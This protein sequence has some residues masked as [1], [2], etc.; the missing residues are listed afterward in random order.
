MSQKPPVKINRFLLIYAKIHHDSYNC[1]CDLI[2]IY[3][4]NNVSQQETADQY[5]KR[6]YEYGLQ[7]N[8]IFEFSVI[9]LQPY[10]QLPIRS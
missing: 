4:V 3:P 10:I 6:C 1:V 7:Q 9:I 8:T 2:I 5:R